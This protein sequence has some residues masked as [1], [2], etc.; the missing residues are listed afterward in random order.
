MNPN[1]LKRL[2]PNASASVLAAN[3]GDYGS[4]QLEEVKNAKNA[5]PVRPVIAPETKN[6]PMTAE[7]MAPKNAGQSFTVPGTPV[8][9][10]RMTQQDKW[11]KRPCV[12]R[13][14]D[15]SNRVKAAAGEVDPAAYRVEFY[16]YMP[17][18]PS[19][20]KRKRATMSGTLHRLR[21]DVDNIGKGLLDSLFKNDGQIAILHG[22]KYWEDERGP[23]TEITI[24]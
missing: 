20:S 2:F 22:E 19:I 21:G 17:I 16:A 5:E 18:P 11:M 7:T 1:Q 13:Y 23:R 6:R 4:G 24:L 14:R 12:M 9:C 10:P 3:S 15:W 8:P